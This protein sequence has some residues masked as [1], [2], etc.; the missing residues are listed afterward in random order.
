MLDEQVDSVKLPLFD[1][2]IGIFPGRAPMVGRVG[3]GEMTVWNGNNSRVWFVDG[4]FVQVVDNTVSVLTDRALPPVEIDAE[5][6]SR[7]LDRV[8]AVVPTTEAGFDN[9]FR[10]QQRYRHMIS[11]RRTARS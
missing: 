5:E 2:L 6:A 3:Y 1:G 7:N 4:G 11:A 9:K 10:D 8:N